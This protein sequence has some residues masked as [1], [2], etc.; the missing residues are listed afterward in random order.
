MGRTTSLP[1]GGGQFQ[2]ENRKR[3]ADNVTQLIR[4]SQQNQRQASRNE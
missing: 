1:E 3:L 4:S 2:G